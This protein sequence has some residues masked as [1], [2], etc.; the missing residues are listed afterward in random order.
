MESNF[1]SDLFFTSSLIFY[2]VAAVLYILYAAFKNE[3]I[4]KSAT[5]FLG[6]GIVAQTVAFVFRTIEVKHAP[7]VT[8]YESEIG[9]AH[10]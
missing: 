7:F 3:K 4:A 8:T 10:V 6:V 2:L 1:D 5:W 9:R